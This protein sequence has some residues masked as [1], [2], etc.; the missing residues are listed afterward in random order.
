MAKKYRKLLNKKDPRDR[1]IL[2]LAKKGKLKVE[3]VELENAKPLPKKGKSKNQF[4][5]K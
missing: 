3:I 1:E 5:K 4:A 2:K